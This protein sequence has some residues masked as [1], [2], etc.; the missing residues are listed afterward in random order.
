MCRC[1]HLVRGRA[2]QDQS[3]AAAGDG[4]LGD[5]ILLRDGVGCVE[6]LTDQ[7]RRWLHSNSLIRL[8]LRPRGD[9]RAVPTPS[10]QRTPE[11]G[12]QLQLGHPL[13]A[14]HAVPLGVLAFI[15]LR[16]DLEG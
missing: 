12:H 8:L 1:P 11:G 14:G 16:P 6:V 13:R 5:P 10:K 7:R 2:R 3:C 9:L 4:V 15:Q